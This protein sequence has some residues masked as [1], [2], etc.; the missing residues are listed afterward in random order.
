MAEA[1]TC[2]FE[3]QAIEDRIIHETDLIVS[4]LS[5]P[6]ISSGH[7]LIIPKRHIEPPE[8]LTKYEGQAIIEEGQRL[9]LYMLGRLVCQGVDYFHKSRPQV[10]QGHNGTKVNHWH[11]HVIP[12]RTKTSL[13][14]KGL[15]WGNKSIWHPLDN[16]DAQRYIEE[17]KG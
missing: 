13:Y 6:A 5:D 15:A 7:S 10:P 12:S 16:D 9:E 2:P 4:F 14:E 17:L 3:R 11:M 8:P 1:Q